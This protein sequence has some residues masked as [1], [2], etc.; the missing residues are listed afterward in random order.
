MRHLLLAVLL[1][2]P[3]TVLTQ[4]PQPQA[5]PPAPPI[6]APQD[7]PYPGV[8]QLHV[9]ATDLAHRIFTVRETIPVPSAGPFT[10]LYPEWLPG[11]HS[12]TG[13][14]QELAGLILRASGK[15]L[16][17][18]RDPVDVFAFHLTV[19]AGVTA[20]DA[21]FQ[22]LT[23]VTSSVGA[24]AMTPEMLDLEWNSVVLYPAG[25][26]SRDIQVNPSLRVADGWHVATA[27]ET[28]SAT[29]A[30]T[31]FKQVTLNTLVDSPAYA[32]R[33]MKQFDL[34]P[35]GAAHVSLDVFADRPD[36]LAAPDEAVAAHRAL[37]QQAY[38]LFQSHHYAHYDFL[39][40]LSDELSGNGLEHHQSSEDGTDADYFTDWAN[41]FPDR[42]LLAHEY[43][44]SWNGKFRRPADLWTPN[45]NVPMRDSLLW[46]YEGQTEYWGYVLT[47]RAGLWTK[48]QALDAIAEVAAHYDGERGREWRA[49]EDTT[50]DPVI[51]ERR[52]LSWGSWQ[53]S[54]D[55]Y[56]EG[57]LIWIDADT[58]I[59]ERSNGAKSLDDFA[60]AFFGIE[61]GRYTTVTYTFDDVVKALNAVV[62]NDWAAFLRTR[63]ESH[64]PGA[65]LDGLTRGGY[66]LTYTSTPSEFTKTSEQRSHAADFEFSIGADVN[67]D[68]T[69]RGVQWEGP[70]FKA[71]L[72]DG[73]KVL[74][75]N[76]VEYSA[77][78]LKRAIGDASGTK[79]PVDLMVQ[80]GKRIWT[81]HLDYHDG[82]KYPHLERIADTPARLDEILTAK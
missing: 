31:T 13:S 10:L 12:P 51:A 41:T 40:S 19:P 71:G 8:I 33:Y 58:L 37:V 1:L 81:A 60:R 27:L 20:I 66:R 62:P 53:R 24:V 54:E 38:K 17:W 34:D 18:T 44:H 4:S 43:T 2:I 50:N 49:L 6:P 72:T 36:E 11:T 42:D 70:A 3:A 78:A 63:L 30:E 14:V 32:G 21:E 79:K 45:F 15:R 74:A 80:W 22:C 9:D 39:F 35:G 5:A 68:G 61:D 7:R 67:D 82:L 46:V 26:F 77:D 16:E 73:T 64:G 57:Q 55:Y 47:A 69:L 52:P 65:P 75:V 28:A 76:G 29:G 59:R 25:Y 23:P 48:Q 56:F